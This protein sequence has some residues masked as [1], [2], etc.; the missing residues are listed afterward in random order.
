[1]VLKSEFG[2]AGKGVRLCAN[3]AEASKAFSDL[4]AAGQHPRIVVQQFVRGTLGMVAAVAVDG[5]VLECVTAMKV[6]SYPGETSPCSVV[7]FIESEEMQG[8]LA[9]LIQEYGFTGFCSGDFIIEG[10]TQS[11]YL[12]EFNPR[13]VPLCN[14]A[15]LSGRSLCLALHS[16]FSGAGYQRIAPQTDHGTVALFPNEWAR[17][18]QSHYLHSAYHDVPWDDPSLLK[19]IIDSCSWT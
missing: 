17:D 4:S 18:P 7:K 15:E 9:R 13:P 8:C 12:L 5:K 6:H 19:T 2:Y 10:G 14:I 1:V 16:H 11:A 3:S